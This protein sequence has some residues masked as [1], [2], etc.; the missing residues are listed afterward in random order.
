MPAL[1]TLRRLCA[2]CLALT[3][4]AAALPVARAASPPV[5]LE[6]PSARIRL[7][8]GLAHYEA[9]RFEDAARAFA[10]AYAIEPAPFLLYS[11]A[12]AE[13]HAGDC[14]RAIELFER[15]LATAPPDDQAQRA[16][17]KII[18]CDGIPP[19]ATQPNTPVDDTSATDPGPP[20]PPDP[21]APPTDASPR[22]SD[23]QPKP[24]GMSPLALGLGVSAL[25]VGAGMGSAGVLLVDTG[26]TR[27]TD[28]LQAPD[29][30]TFVDERDAAERR[31]TAGWVLVGVGGAFV[32]AG[33]T[34]LVV[35]SVR[36][37]RSR[38]STARLRP[39]ATGL[40]LAF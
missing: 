25:V 11:W 29:Q 36:A 10:D 2:P 39:A 22:A 8:E 24:S 34:T 33:I 40:A 4:T 1:V 7:E 23:T 17:S 37:R 19:A 26:G 30:Q 16:R 13:R 35:A 6:D 5:P 9:Q 18:E 38:P 31:Q 32:V 15:F 28:A 27:R 14:S 3:M 12:Q 20:P 21:I